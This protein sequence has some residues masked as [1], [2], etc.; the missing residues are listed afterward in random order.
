MLSVQLMIGM[1]IRTAILLHLFC[2]EISQLYMF[3][4][5][6]DYY[7]DTDGQPSTLIIKLLF[8]PL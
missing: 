1:C 5:N 3:E 2:H 7:H 8:L 6:G 4:G